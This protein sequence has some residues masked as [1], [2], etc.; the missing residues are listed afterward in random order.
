MRDHS[1]VDSS[2][3]NGRPLTRSSTQARTSVLAEL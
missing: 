3:L 1:S 2:S